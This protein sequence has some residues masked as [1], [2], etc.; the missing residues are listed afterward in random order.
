MVKAARLLMPRT[1]RYASASQQPRGTMT[2]PPAVQPHAMQRTGTVN[3]EQGGPEVKLGGAWEDSTVGSMF[4]TDSE[5]GIP[6]DSDSQNG[7]GRSYSE[8]GTYQRARGASQLYR[9]QPVQSRSNGDDEDLP[10]VIGHNGFLRVVNGPA[11]EP[12]P[13]SGPMMADTPADSKRLK[14]PKPTEVAFE[15]QRPHYETTPTKSGLRRARRDGQE[16]KRSSFTER[17]HALPDSPSSGMTPERSPE[18]APK[19]STGFQHLGPLDEVSANFDKTRAAVGL[20]SSDEQSD[21]DMEDVSLHD[22]PRASRQPR[23]LPNGHMQESR[24]ETGA[25][26]RRAKEPAAAAQPSKKR[27]QDRISLDYNDAEL[28]QMSYADLRAQAFDFDPQ[29]AADRQTATPSAGTLEAKLQHYRA[30][31]SET[32]HQF[33]TGL[34]VTEWEEAG[35][36]FLEQFTA[37]VAGFKT[38]RRA[39]R[40]LVRQFEAEVDA[41]EEAVRGKTEGIGRTLCDL[42]QEGQSMMQGKAT[43]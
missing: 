5:R 21:D 8:A 31:D 1:G 34:S 11:D 37:A 38:A 40:D 32:Q 35:D 12:R 16:N 36:W 6:K 30:K 17:L 13:T 25:H 2:P 10:F 18:A 3:S 24:H 19:R 41:R 29:K 33:F 23:A 20:P 4:A 39:K 27:S 15:D 42:K 43:E 7:H 22:T 28:D 9:G 26:G 14:V